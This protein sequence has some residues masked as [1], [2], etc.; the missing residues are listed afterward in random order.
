MSTSVL[1]YHQRNMLDIANFDNINDQ[2][3]SIPIPIFYS[4]IITNLEKNECFG[5]RQHLIFF[6]IYSYGYISLLNEIVSRLS[7]PKISTHDLYSS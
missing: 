1:T 4:L 6:V 7:N 5:S 3:I 2:P